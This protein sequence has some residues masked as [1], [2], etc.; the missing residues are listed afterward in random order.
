MKLYIFT[1]QSLLH[2]NMNTFVRIYSYVC[3]CFRCFCNSDY[4]SIEPTSKEEMPISALDNNNEGNLEIRFSQF[5]GRMMGNEVGLLELIYSYI[6]DL[7][8][9]QHQQAPPVLIRY[10]DQRPSLAVRRSRRWQ[11]WSKR[12]N[13]LWSCLRPP[14]PFDAAHRWSSKVSQGFQWSR[15]IY[16]PWRLTLKKTRDKSYW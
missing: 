1:D 2:V 6:V 15:W 7:F 3:Q 11:L 13:R 14:P 4:Q 5:Y 9:T 16:L 12:R 10:T 8:H